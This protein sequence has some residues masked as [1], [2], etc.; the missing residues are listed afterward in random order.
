MPEKQTRRRWA[1][2]ETEY[3]FALAREFII[4][5]GFNPRITEC[6][7]F[8]Q[9]LYERFGGVNTRT[10]PYELRD[11]RLVYL[12]MTRWGNRKRRFEALCESLLGSRWRT[13]RSATNHKSDGGS[14]LVFRPKKHKDDDGEGGQGFGGTGGGGGIGR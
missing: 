6:K 1:S 14:G 8:A 9:E 5:N 2:E 7:Q 12:H 4:T 3:L 13:I 10:G 11:A